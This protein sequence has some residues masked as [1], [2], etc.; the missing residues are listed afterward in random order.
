MAVRLRDPVVVCAVAFI[1]CFVRARAAVH[2]VVAPVAPEHVELGVSHHHITK[3][4]AHHPFHVRQRVRAALSVF[5]NACG[6][7]HHHPGDRVHVLHVIKACTTVD[8]VIALSAFEFVA[9]RITQQL[10]VACAATRVLD[11]DQLVCPRRDVAFVVSRIRVHQA[12]KHANGRVR[13][14]CAVLSRAP[15]QR[16]AARAPVDLIVAVTAYQ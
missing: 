15:V 12:H 7:V 6:Q 9:T 16:V 2:R 5:G 4:A 14:V 3:R 11:R 13:V 8:G 10:V 1:A